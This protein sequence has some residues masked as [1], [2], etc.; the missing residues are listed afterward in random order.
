M[1]G[2][3]RTAVARRSRRRLAIWSVFAALGISMGAVWATGFASIGGANGSSSASPPITSTSGSTTTADLAG[4]VTAG[5]AMQVDW[6]G[7]WGSTPARTMFTVDLTS[8]SSG[9]YNAALLLT[10]DI[11]GHGWDTLQVKF[12]LHDD[13]T[14][15]GSCADSD[16]DG[17]GDTEVMVFDRQDAAA[18]WTGLAAGHRYCI[19][20]PAASAPPADQSGTFIR[21]S[22]DTVAPD[23]FPTFV[24]T[25]NRA[26]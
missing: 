24:A 22:S 14:A 3:S 1:R 13:G 26:S 21:R 23:L 12:E 10:N 9:T 11:S 19:G 18:Y 2:N 5:N 15:A 7:Y 16:I 17:S 25:L 4:L 6:A 8:K 20:V